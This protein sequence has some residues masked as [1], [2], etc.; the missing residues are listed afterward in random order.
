MQ[1][2]DT[3]YKFLYL[4]TSPNSGFIAMPFV[5]AYTLAVAA[6]LRAYPPRPALRKPANVVRHCCVSLIEM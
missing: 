4:G 5:R 6:A 2:K 3:G 1:L